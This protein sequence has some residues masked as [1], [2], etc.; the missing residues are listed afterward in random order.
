V[1]NKTQKI[2][3]NRKRQEEVHKRINKEP[4][5]LSQKLNIPEEEE[6]IPLSLL[7][8]IKKA[9]IGTTNTNPTKK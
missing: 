1:E 2:W 7:T 3:Q 5:A 6:N 4:G 9:K 8:R